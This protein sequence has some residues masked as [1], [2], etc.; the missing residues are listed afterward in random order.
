MSISELSVLFQPLL[1]LW[2]YQRISCQSHFQREKVVEHR[3][4]EALALSLAFARLACSSL[5]S[6]TAWIWAIESDDGV[7]LQ[8]KKL[9]GELEKS[10]S[11]FACCHCSA[12]RFSTP[13]VDIR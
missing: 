12:I 8:K 13:I 7:F 5:S 4:E 11:P 2:A 9:A 3:E 10:F 1:L 6:R